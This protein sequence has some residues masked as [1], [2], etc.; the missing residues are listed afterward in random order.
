M[1]T[2]KTLN[3]FNVIGV[4]AYGIV[5]RGVET[6][7]GMSLAVKKSRVSIRVKRSL[8]RYEARVVQVL[9]GHPAIPAIYG[10]GRFPHFEYLAMELGGK[11]VKELGQSNQ[12]RT[13]LKTVILLALQMISA[14]QHIHSRGFIHRDVKPDHILIS[15]RDPNRF[16]FVDYGIACPR[17]QESAIQRYSPETERKHVV[18]TLKWASLNAH[19]GLRQSTSTFKHLITQ[20]F[21]IELSWR[22]DLESLGYVL[23]FLLRGNLPW[24]SSPKG[25]TRVGAAVRLRMAKTKWSGSQLAHGY[26]PE[27]GLF[28]DQTRALEFDETPPYERYMELFQDLYRRSGFSDTD[29]SLDWTSVQS[30]AATLPRELLFSLSDIDIPLLTS[31]PEDS[32]PEEKSQCNHQL[33]PGQI[34]SAQVMREASI[35]GITPGDDLWCM[36]E[37]ETS[38]VSRPAV[39]VKAFTD[40]AGLQHVTLAALAR[41]N[42]PPLGRSVHF[43]PGHLETVPSWPLDD[44]YCYVF[45][46]P[47]SCIVGTIMVSETPAESPCIKS[48]FGMLQG[49]TEYRVRDEDISLLQREFS[50]VMTDEEMLDEAG[51]VVLEHIKEYDDEA[52]LLVRIESL[53]LP[54]QGLDWTGT[55]GWFDEIKSIYTHRAADDGWR[56]AGF[57]SAASAG[58]EVLSNSYSGWDLANWDNRQ[59][60]R[61]ETLSLRDLPSS[62]SLGLEELIPEITEV[63]EDDDDD[64]EG[65]GDDGGDGDDD[66]N[67][68]FAGS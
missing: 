3:L 27:F 61:D 16:I 38:S 36:V 43:R 45:P 67:E 59:E 62:L 41:G 15:L 22:D 29:K 6:A 18:G 33:A 55:S 24:V 40:E 31:H 51:R 4:G 57:V 35:L 10:Y 17:S 49:D 7:S 9:S 63:N 44:T 2:T 23:L 11:N 8:L 54:G 42:C 39:V 60:E 66:S 1:S 26:P 30:P 5:L 28:L 25:G 65:E 21:V 13:P 50:E 19:R 32:T 58:R 20:G 47:M 37:S 34:V 12:G 48:S 52:P 53:R 14:L 68:E 56:W 46:Q 64:S